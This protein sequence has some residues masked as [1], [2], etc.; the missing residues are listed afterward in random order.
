MRLF[1]G[2]AFCGRTLRHPSRGIF[3]FYVQLFGPA[4]RHQVVQN[5]L[6]GREEGG[7]FL[8]DVSISLP[9]PTIDCAL[10][11]KNGYWLRDNPG[12]CSVSWV[13]R[14]VMA[15]RGKDRVIP[16]ATSLPSV[17]CARRNGPNGRALRLPW[18]LHPTRST[19][20]A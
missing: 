6:P 16:E 11:P 18:F 15:L 12:G 8:R 2:Y 20:Q 10:F 1:F 9:D 17:V 5:F 4:R 7:F 3:D 14:S 13:C 19:A